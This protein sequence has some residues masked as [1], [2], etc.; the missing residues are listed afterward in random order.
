MNIYDNL[1]FILDIYNNKKIKENK[2]N[3]NEIEKFKLMVGEC[4]KS[5]DINYD[6][7]LNNFPLNDFDFIKNKNIIKFYFYYN[8]DS[9]VDLGG[10]QSLKIYE[11]FIYIFPNIKKDIYLIDS[12]D[13]EIYEPDELTKYFEGKEKYLVCLTGWTHKD[14]GH[15]INIVLERIE[16]NYNI[17]IINSGDGLYYHYHKLYSD[18]Y[19]NVFRM[20]IVIIYK[21]K[22]EEYIINLF[23]NLYI[24]KKLN[25]LNNR[26]NNRE[27]YVSFET[28]LKTDTSLNKEVVLV[29]ILEDY[30]KLN[31]ND[32]K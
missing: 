24:F 4:F 17:Y 26:E 7:R 22:G 28:L 11:I 10:Y 15:A 25:D 29:N 23:R 18:L 30:L 8:Y 21:N 13:N 20:P 32:F 16:T 2:I 31:N 3:E 27:K 5:Y 9:K 19:Y 12:F 1:S 6:S 14:K